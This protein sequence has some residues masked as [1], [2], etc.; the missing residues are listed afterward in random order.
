MPK[1][2]S[3]VFEGV[4]LGRKLRLGFKEWC[5]ITGIHEGSFH[6]KRVT[7]PTF[8]DLLDSVSPKAWRQRAKFL[9]GG[10]RCDPLLK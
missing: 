8:Q 6:H 3:N 10:K 9:Y 1:I 2:N 5:A 4:W 7:S